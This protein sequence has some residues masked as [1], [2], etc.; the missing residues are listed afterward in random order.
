MEPQ[1]A[2]SGDILTSTEAGGR[3]I[4]GSAL[5]AAGN[6]AGVVVGVVTAALLLRHLGVAE[7]GRYVT[8]LSLVAIAGSVSENGLNVSASRE[9]ALLP[10]PERSA[11]I[12]NVVGQ[13]LVVTPLA[14]LAMVA[15]AA[16]AGYP[17]RMIAGT[18]LAGAG[19]LIMALA[20]SLLLP[21]TVELR[22]AGLAFIDFFRQAVTLAG[23]AVLVIVG[24][25]LLPFFAVQIVVGLA[26]L[27]L[28]PRLAGA[29]AFIAPSFDRAK[30]R[31]LLARALPLAVAIVLGQLYFR[32]VIVLI[33]LVSS[34]RPPG[35]FG[36][37][38]F[39]GVL[40]P[41]F[42]AQGGAV[43]SVA[44][45]ALLAALIYW[46][47]RAGIGTG[48][49]MVGARFLLRVTAAAV[50]ACVPLLVSA[51]PDFAAAA[52]AGVVFLGVGQLVGILPRELHEALRARAPF[53][54]P[55]A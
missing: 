39:A 6:A 8:V 47:L 49:V 25:R 9:L 31:A 30:H 2:V 45:D 52:L 20:N 13:R 26:V 48:A 16:V 17:A 41:L 50:A 40:V 7:S 15:F 43:A 10:R 44:G 21:L 53:A 5:R 33:S 46:R 54:R 3:V 34:P 18:A 35:L 22:N 23:V 37:G 32:L 11:L 4:R 36:V 28:V 24:A 1:E 42:D 19:M 27:A 51:L 29:G 12:A 38:V 55:R 14:V